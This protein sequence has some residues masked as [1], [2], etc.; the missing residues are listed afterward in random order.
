VI[1]GTAIGAFLRI[2]DEEDDHDGHDVDDDD[3]IIP[4]N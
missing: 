1:V 2:L 4:I 3:E